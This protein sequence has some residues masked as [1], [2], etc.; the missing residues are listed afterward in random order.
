MDNKTKEQ[1]CCIACYI[2]PLF[3]IGL[4]LEPGNPRVR[5][6]VGQGLN[7]FLFEV[8]GGIVARVVGR[9]PLIG[10]VGGLCGF[11]VGVLGLLMMI[12]GII[13]AVS[14]RDKPLPILG[15]FQLFR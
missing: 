15:A 9:L 14:N 11:A 12:L 1:L 13:N 4:L 8:A 7:L 3:L 5:F 10:F 2:G 6:H